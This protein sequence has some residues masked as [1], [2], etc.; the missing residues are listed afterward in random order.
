MVGDANFASLS[1][2]NQAL[3]TFM[4][5][6]LSSILSLFAPWAR[7][8]IKVSSATL[9]LRYS[10]L[11]SFLSEAL[12][13]K[14]D[15][16]KS[17]KFRVKGD[18]FANPDSR[19]VLLGF[20]ADPSHYSTIGFNLHVRNIGDDGVSLVA[21]ER[22]ILGYLEVRAVGEALNER[23]KHLVNTISSKHA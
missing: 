11:V 10:E 2:H 13:K 20:S 3:G 17:A 16:G 6:I 14:K 22:V 5:K 19:Q 8:E 18:F 1:P 9:G 15:D 4:L 12:P 21:E 23:L 7:A